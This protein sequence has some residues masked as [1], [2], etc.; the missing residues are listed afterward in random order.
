[1]AA[2]SLKVTSKVTTPSAPSCDAGRAV[3]LVERWLGHPEVPRDVRLQEF[4]EM[5]EHT[6]IAIAPFDAQNGAVGFRR[7]L[8]LRRRRVRAELPT[9]LSTKADDNRSIY[10]YITRPQAWKQG[11]STMSPE[12]VAAPEECTCFAVRQ[13]ARRVTQFYDQFLAPRASGRRSSRSSPSF[14][15]WERRRSTNWPARW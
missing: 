10:A 9:L 7:V 12:W 11:R 15:G 3:R 14:G 8:S 5:L 6:G 4:E 13:A 1:M 2:R